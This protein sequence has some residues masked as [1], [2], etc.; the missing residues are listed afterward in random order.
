MRDDRGETLLELLIAV[1]ILGIGA[2]A[3]GAGLT[4]GVLASDLHRKQSTAGATVRDYAEA[5]QNRVATGGYTACAGPGAYS[6]PPGFTAPAGYAA[7]VTA[8]KYWSGSAWQ[9]SCPADTGLQQ[10]TLQ[11]SASDGRAV[12]RVV[13]VVRKPCG[14][15]QALCG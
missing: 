13:I 10:L 4:T 11:V 7:S 9:A 3:I 12:E 14:L 1:V 6:A 8:T 5:I 2:V 15:G